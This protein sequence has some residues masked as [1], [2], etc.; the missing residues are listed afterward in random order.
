MTPVEAMQWIEVAA[1]V[2]LLAVAGVC[3]YKFI[4]E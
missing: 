3:F 1:V 4:R 2:L